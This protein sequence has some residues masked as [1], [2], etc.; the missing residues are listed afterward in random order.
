MSVCVSVEVLHVWLEDVSGVYSPVR[1]R[2][3]RG[4]SEPDTEKRPEEQKQ[5]GIVF[6]KVPLKTSMPDHVKY[7][8]QKYNSLRA[9]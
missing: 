4:D 6:T 8:I 3:H 1:E 2:L 5:V 7:L 9:E